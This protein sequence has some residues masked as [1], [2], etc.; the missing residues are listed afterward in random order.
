MAVVG[1]GVMALGCVTDSSCW[2]GCDVFRLFCVFLGLR[3]LHFFG[4]SVIS[5]GY[6]YYEYCYYT[7]ADT[8]PLFFS[9]T[10]GV[11]PMFLLKK[12]LF[13]KSETRSVPAP[14]LSGAVSA[15]WNGGWVGIGGREGGARCLN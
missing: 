5:C 8:C 7:H 13:K 4:Y 11:S 9:S 10:V 6:Y 3:G 1:L 12:D 14:W 15:P 2:L